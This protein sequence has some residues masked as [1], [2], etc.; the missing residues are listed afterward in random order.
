MKKILVPVLGLLISVALFAQ[1]RPVTGKVSN[2]EG[3]P[4]QFATISVK[5]ATGGK[6]ADENGTFTIDAAPIPHL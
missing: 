5:G 1:K 4:V 3:K 2:A 6:S